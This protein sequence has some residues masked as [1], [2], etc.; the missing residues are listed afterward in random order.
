MFF[1]F[2]LDIWMFLQVFI[3]KSYLYIHNK[4][5]YVSI[6]DYQFSNDRYYTLF[7]GGFPKDPPLENNENKSCLN[8]FGGR[9]RYLYSNLPINLT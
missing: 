9:T 1:T 3:D 8:D 6:L 2:I 4:F 5:R 7:Y